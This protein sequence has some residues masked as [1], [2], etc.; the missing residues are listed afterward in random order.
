MRTSTFRTQRHLTTLALPAA[1]IILLTAMCLMVLSTPSPTV[2]AA[3]GAMQPSQTTVTL[4]PVADAYI[5]Q[6]APTTNYGS[7]TRL[8]VQNLDAEIPDDRRSYVGF[9]LSAIPSNAVIT[10]AGFKAYLYEALGSSS[11]SVQLRRV[12]SAWAFNTVTW[13]SRPA[14]T[15]YRTI[16][17]GTQTRTYGWDVTSLVQNYWINR[18]FGA[19]PNFGLELRGPTSGDY[20]LRRF[21]SA[22]STTNR[23]SLVVS[24][25]VPTP[26]P[27]VTSVIPQVD[28]WLVE[29]CDRSYPVGTSVNIRYRANV[30][31][32][33]QIWVYPDGQLVIQHAVVANQLYG[34][35]ATVSAP[36]EQR[37]L[38]AVL[39]NSKAQDECHY[40]VV[41]PSPTATATPSPTATRTPTATPTATQ[42][43]T[44]TPTA[45]ATPTTTPTCTDAYEPNDSFDQA[46]F[47][48]PGAIQSYICDGSDEDYF[49]FAVK[50]GDLIH[51][52]LRNL[53]AN[54]DLCLYSP[55][56]QELGCSTA[57]GTS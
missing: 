7:S 45:T 22:N 51:L 44:R 23:P 6:A 30:N 21:Y 43:P 4:Y 15:S 38:V 37:R 1:A 31:D 26:T 35:Q 14:S 19:S 27:T 42:T 18:D 28:I 11:V 55:G 39:V 24:Y 47:L 46:W 34:F 9:D 49:K 2:R 13:N 32:T 25:Y 56:R 17:V 36:A 40:T 8:D 57:G 3:P 33:V 48:T 41:E 29:G 5:S 10:S 54:Y 50:A 16:S 53:P 20:Y 52:S 12:T